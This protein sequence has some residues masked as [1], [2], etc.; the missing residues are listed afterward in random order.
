MFIWKDW[1][2]VKLMIKTFLLSSLSICSPFQ[3]FNFQSD[4]F[5]SFKFQS[6]NFQ[7]VNFQSC[8]FHPCDVV[9]LFPVLQFPVLQIQLSL[10]H[11]HSYCR[12]RIWCWA[13][14]CRRCWMFVEWV[15]CVWVRCWFVFWADNSNGSFN[16]AVFDGG[17]KT[18]DW[19]RRDGRK[20][21]VGKRETGKRG[22]KTAG[23]ENTGKGV[24]G[25]PNV[26]VYVNY[27]SNPTHVADKWYRVSAKKVMLLRSVR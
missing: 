22:T 26:I 17:L 18:R 23:V 19:N 21:K 15:H 9:R 6:V 16:I 24:Y 13:S 1:L 10:R 11:L 8:N 25:Q 7:S 2:M 4:K 5:Q 12:S 27:C 3:S 20:C 14:S